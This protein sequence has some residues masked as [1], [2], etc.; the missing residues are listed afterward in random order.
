MKK[1]CAYDDEATND[2]VFLEKYHNIDT[3]FAHI[4]FFFG[5]LL[6]LDNKFVR[7]AR[8]S[9]QIDRNGEQKGNKKGK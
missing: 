6:Q 2:D 4:F 8:K 3:T 9:Y 1:H 5:F 7:H